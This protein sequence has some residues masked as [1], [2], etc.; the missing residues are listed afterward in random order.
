MSWNRRPT[1][2]FPV[3]VLKPDGP[4]PGGSSTTAGT[5]LHVPVSVIHCGLLPRVACAADELSTSPTA[6]MAADTAKRRVQCAKD[7]GAL[8]CVADAA[9]GV[10]CFICSPLRAREPKAA[11]VLALSAARNILISGLVGRPRGV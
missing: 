1:P 11:V 10:V 9:A 4:G 6:A 3:S 8:Q 7:V 2:I 5:P